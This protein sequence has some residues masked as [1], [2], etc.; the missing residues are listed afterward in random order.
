M[1]PN[2]RGDNATSR[3]AT[4]KGGGSV[5]TPEESQDIK[6]ALDG[7]KFLEKFSLLCPPA[8]P[9]SNGS[10]AYCLHQISAMA[11]VPKQTVNAIRASAFLLEE[12][13]DTA[14]NET[15]RTAFDSQITE[16]TSDMGL[17][18]EDAKLKIDQHLKE[19]FEQATKATGTTQ[20]THNHN[21]QAHSTVRTPSAANPYASA[22]INPPPNVNPILAA[23]EGIKTRQF[24]ITGLGESALGIHDT[25]KLK[26]ALNKTARDLG[27]KE[28]KIRSLITQKDGSVL[29][30]VDTDASVV[31]FTND[32]N[33]I[34]FCSALGDGVAFKTRIY[35]VLAFNVPLNL[36][37]SEESHLDEINE[38]NDLE[39]NTIMTIR[40]AKPINRR[41][42]HQRSAHLVLSFSNPD[43][44]NRA[45]TNGVT[46]CNKK[47]HVEKI[48]R[49]P[50][51]CLKCQRWNH[52]ARDCTEQVNT[53]SNCAGTHKTDQCIHPHI[54]RCVSCKSDEHAS[55]SRQCPT[56]LR[57]V[58]DFKERNP[59]SSLP[60]FPTADPWT[61]STDDANPTHTLKRNSAT[62]SNPHISQQQKGKGRDK[63]P[64]G[65]YG[66]GKFG[67]AAWPAHL[68]LDL[69][70]QEQPPQNS[71]WN[72]PPTGTT[73]NQ[74]Q[75]TQPNHTTQPTTITQNANAG[76]SN[77]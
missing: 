36:S 16:F 28:G 11:G 4:R 8:Q 59:E 46:I 26:T 55:W 7:R 53:C 19:S 10:L 33:R 34:E 5:T 50:I 66:T 57:R 58:E 47:C 75:P 2:A 40:W 60:Y 63:G 6:N 1:A 61:W 13:E 9:T 12:L 25:Q 49:E 54:T 77:V 17:L 43:D 71:W 56:L 76:P 39:D 42:P 69:D 52:M 74:H 3:P 70:T 62:K 31:W 37:P 22:L 44:A 21:A 15:I 67:P 65:P 30:E 14:I 23:K 41:T 48:R 73:R 64:S 27:L 51:R 24:L 72:D 20:L 18:I 38:A 32:I 29:I 35:N 45:I 68:N